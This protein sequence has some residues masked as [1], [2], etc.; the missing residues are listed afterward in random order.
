MYSRENYRPHIVAAFV[1]TV[2]ILVSFQVYIAREP[3]RIEADETADQELALAAGRD[4]YSDNCADCHGA[5]GE[6]GIGP[7]FNSQQLLSQTT[8]EVFFSLT[9]TGIPGTGMPAWSQAFGGPFTD[10]QIMQLVIYIRAWEPNSPELIAEVTEPDPVQGAAIYTRTCSVCHGQDG[11][12]TDTAP[13]INNAR[14]LSRLDDTWYRNTIAHGRPAKGMP[15][16]G[17]VLSPTQINDLVALIG[18]WREGE[19]VTADISLA[20]YLSNAT[21]AVRNF[22]AIDAEF[23]LNAAFTKA[24]SSQQAQIR[25]VIALVQAGDWNAAQ[26]GINTLLPPEEMGLA[27]FANNCSACHGD[28]GRGGLATNLRGNTFIQI[29]GDEDLIE[30]I[31]SGRSGTA[32]DGFQGI[33]AEEELVNLVILLRSWQD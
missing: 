24:T 6:G 12:G 3:A 11:L 5:D 17:T 25:A 18:V 29:Q 33:L 10:E 23:F 8:D 27:L 2:G 20:T 30:F 9:R 26:S 13:A 1:L 28:D 21:F 14:R 16:W 32:M 22:D 19:T 7:A 4:L 15:T 31:L